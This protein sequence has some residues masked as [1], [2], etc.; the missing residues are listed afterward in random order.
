MA[1]GM[2]HNKLPA[3]PKQN[4]KSLPAGRQDCNGKKPPLKGFMLQMQ[5]NLQNMVWWGVVTLMIL[6]LVGL[7]FSGDKAT[8]EIQLSQA[9]GDIRAGKVAKVD[10]MAERLELI[11][12]N[13]KDHAFSRKEGGES[14]TEIL[15]RSKID[16]A[17]VEFEI[18]DQ[19]MGQILGA[20]LPSIIGTGFI[21]LVLLYMFRQARGAQDSLFSFGQSKARLFDKGKPSTKFADVAGVD[22]AK[23]ELEE[24]VDFLKNPGKYKAVGART[25]KGV[26]LVGPS[27]VGKTLLARAVAGEA[28]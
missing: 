6:S 18:K 12:K 1:K 10:V 23:K 25:P 19:T 11:Y 20:A 21:M 28:S 2:V 3:P 22:E 16:P 5:F 13:Q 17:A 4:G 7:W 9:L 27:G 26:L 14:F 24:V 15:D 8:K